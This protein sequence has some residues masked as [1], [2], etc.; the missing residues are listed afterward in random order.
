MAEP[1]I[2]KVGYT[3][4]TGGQSKAYIDMETGMGTDKHSDVEVILYWDEALEKWIQI[5]NYEWDFDWE[6]TPHRRN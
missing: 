4:K 6:G 2:G 1:D 3:T 5:D